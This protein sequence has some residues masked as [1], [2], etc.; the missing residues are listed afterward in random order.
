MLAGWD[1]E[2]V[3]KHLRWARDGGIK[4]LIEEDELNPR[5]WATNGLA[6]WRYRQ[7]EPFTGTSRA[8]WVLGAQ[9]SGTNMVMR[10]LAKHGGVK[11]YNENNSKAFQSF[12]L[13][14]AATVR[15]LIDD[16]KQPV[17]VFKPLCD[18]DRALELLE[19]GGPESRI[20]WIY[21]DV[22]ARARSAVKKFGS[23]NLDMM[24]ALAAQE[25]GSPQEAQNWW[26]RSADGEMRDTI[27]SLNP[28]K[29][30]PHD[31][32]ALFWWMRNSMYFS[33]GL[34]KRDDAVLVSYQKLLAEPSEVMS[35]LCDAMGLGFNPTLVDH[36]EPSRSLPSRLDLDPGV[37]ALCD[38]LSDRLDA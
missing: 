30:S 19:L 38:Q 16:C 21:R 28:E 5:Q 26:N 11:I 33:Q 24:K 7:A 29:L 27:A 35:E 34:D 36:F 18:S 2:K 32:A 37:R 10:G 15:Q 12:E 22:D 25:P 14:P 8:L 6:R 1:A 13:R 17:I 23:A 31:A 3:R 9:R 20:A 4:S